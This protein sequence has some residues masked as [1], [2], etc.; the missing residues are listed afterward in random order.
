MSDRSALATG[1][2]AF[3][4]AGRRLTPRGHRRDT[5][6]QPGKSPSEETALVEFEMKTSGQLV[7]LS[8]PSGGGKSTILKALLQSDTRLAYSVSATTRPA[9][10]S[11]VN[12]VDYHFT[13]LEEFRRLIAANAFYEYF[14]VHGNFYG[15]L[16]AEVDSKLADG[17]DVLLDVDVQGS[18]RLRTLMPECLTVFVLPPSMAVLEARLRGRASDSEEVIQRRL[19]NAEG[20][21]RMADRYDYILINHDLAETVENVRMIIR[22]QRFRATRTILREV[23]PPA[24]RSV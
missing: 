14:E 17:R 8:A 9:R 23:A 2:G 18:M 21:I 15:T 20:E 16:R 19:R 22:A 11:E 7:I 24:A 10:A 13:P 12:G 3:A 6:P 1:T 5:S 4:L